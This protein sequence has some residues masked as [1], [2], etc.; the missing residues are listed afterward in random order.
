MKMKANILIFL[1]VLLSA[2][3]VSANEAIKC[4]EIASGDPNKGGLGLLS[5]SAVELC[6]GTTNANE[7][8]QCYIKAYEQPKEGGL[9]LFSSTAIRLCKRNAL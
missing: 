3:S 6:S 7:T 5:S 1:L 2:G 8:T 4:Y 9:G